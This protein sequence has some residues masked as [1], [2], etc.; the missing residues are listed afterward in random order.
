[1][2]FLEH[3]NYFGFVESAQGKVQA[4]S[5]D[6]TML[7]QLEHELRNKALDGSYPHCPTLPLSSLELERLHL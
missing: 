3:K 7:Q 5:G 6:M 4:M 1:M 2:I